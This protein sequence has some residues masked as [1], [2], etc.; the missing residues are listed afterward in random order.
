MTRSP[1]RSVAFALMAAPLR[2]TF[3]TTPPRFARFAT[4]AAIPVVMGDPGSRRALRRKRGS[5]AT[6]DVAAAAATLK[7]VAA[8]PAG[9]IEARAAECTKLR[10]PRQAL[11]LYDTASP[12]ELAPAY[13]AVSRAL[14]RMGRDGLALELFRRH[15]QSATPDVRSACTLF[16][17]LCRRER[18]DNATALLAE[19]D[20]IAPPPADGVA[21][22]AADGE[23]TLWEAVATTCVPAL[24]L[25]RLQAGDGEEAV[26]L[27]ARM[28]AA[29]ARGAAPELGTCTRLLRALGKARRL[30]GVYGT[31]DA[32]AAGGVRPDA[33]A[34]QAL[35]NALVHSVD[36]VKGG[37]S[38]ETL[39]TSPLPEV[40]FVGRS[41]V[42]KSSLV[43]M[44]RA[45]RL[46]SITTTATTAATL[47]HHLSP[48]QVLGRRAI[49]YTSKTPGKTQQY[50]YFLLNGER[51]DGLGA[52]HL[53]DWPGLGYAK[54]PAR[55]RVAWSNFLAQYLS[56][57]PQLKLLVHLIDGEVGPTDVD[58]SL[59]ATV[60]NLTQ[61]G[62][63][64]GAGWGYAVAL[65]KLDKDK[66]DGKPSEKVE[67]LL[68][69]AL[70]ENGCEE[71]HAPPVATSARATLGRDAMWRLL[72]C[73]MM[74][75]DQT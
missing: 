63:R 44:V 23:E 75:D 59:M 33:E 7:T 20:E 14:L 18:L 35:I 65:T 53:V 36:F 24:A 66:R 54:V 17:A 48:S 50:N 70:A 41:N 64:Y 4:S 39:P 27:V 19:L 29:A 37:V 47:N 55:Q 26:A 40:A 72:R 12:D 42:G 69:E 49:A 52:F 2:A 67:R 28:E 62:G 30:D 13:A 46:A 73:V 21:A 58:R 5:A 61:G 32:M 16:L 9:S 60:G 38:L 34:N 6:P 43:N 15:R 57:R 74:S 68:S 10:M 51:S 8:A 71:L 31:L 11:E 1:L 25:K 22:A 45:A 3:I 56:E